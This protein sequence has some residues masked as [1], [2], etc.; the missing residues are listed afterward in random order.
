MNGRESP[1][2]GWGI[3]CLAGDFMGYWSFDQALEPGDRI[4]FDDMIHYTTVKTTMFNGVHHP[5]IGGGG[6]RRRDSDPS[7][8]LATRIS[9]RDYPDLDGPR[10]PGPLAS[11]GLSFFAPPWGENPSERS[12]HRCFLALPVHTLGACA[13]SRGTTLSIPNTRCFK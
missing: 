12:P 5:G 7:E 8:N 9:R 4:I 3:S 13:C 11:K 1:P 6:V 2:T 10:S